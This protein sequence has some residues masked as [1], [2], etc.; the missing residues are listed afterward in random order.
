MKEAQIHADKRM[1]QVYMDECMC[2]YICAR[3]WVYSERETKRS[4]KKRINIVYA[5][6]ICLSW[7]NIDTAKLILV[8]W[9]NA[10]R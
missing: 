6:N 8:I 5:K 1:T 3:V 9:A 4:R 7:G 2:L 10:Q